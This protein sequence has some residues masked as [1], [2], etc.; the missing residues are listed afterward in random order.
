MR[1]GSREVAAGNIAAVTYLARNPNV[2]SLIYSGEKISWAGFGEWH[3]T[4][5][6]EGFQ[7]SENQH[8]VDTR[9][10]P[11]WTYTSSNLS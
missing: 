7:D 3:A 5:G 9:P 6:M 2:S 11:E 10:I 8:I 1:D 4:S